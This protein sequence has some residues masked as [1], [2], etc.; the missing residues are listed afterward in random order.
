MPT[1][2]FSHAARENENRIHAEH[3]DAEQERL[4]RASA[5]AAGAGAVVSS[6]MISAIGIRNG[7]KTFGSLNS[8]WARLVS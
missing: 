5:S 2:R 3:E 4:R 7:P 1:T 8:A 6:S